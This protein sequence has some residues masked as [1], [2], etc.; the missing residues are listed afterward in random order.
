[1]AKKQEIILLFT[2]DQWKSYES[3]HLVGIFLDPL[4]AKKA[5][6]DLIKNDVIEL[7]KDNGYELS[8]ID[9]YD[10]KYIVDNI[11]TYLYVYVGYDGEFESE[12][13]Y[14]V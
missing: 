13:T 14:L 10:F 8:D 1:M 2:C 12:G 9:D 7:D 11:V 5:I 6:K 4:K 3:M